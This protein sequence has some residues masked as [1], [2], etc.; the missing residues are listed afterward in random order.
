MAATVLML[1]LTHIFM[2]ERLLAIQDV[3]VPRG[4][5][6]F[7]SR[8]DKL[9]HLLNLKDHNGAI[10]LK[11]DWPV[12]DPSEQQDQTE[13]LFEKLKARGFDD[14]IAGN[15][16]RRRM[17]FGYDTHPLAGIFTQLRGTSGSAG[18]SVVRDRLRMNFK[19]REMLGEMVIAADDIKIS[20]TETVGSQRTI[21]MQD[22]T[23]GSFSLTY[24]DGSVSLNLNQLK[25]GAIVVE[26]TIDNNTETFSAQSFADLQEQHF[27][28]VKNWLVP[29]LEHVGFVMPTSKEDSLVKRAVLAKIASIQHRT[30]GQFQRL[31]DELESS[32]FHTR[33]KAS[34]KIKQQFDLWS[35]LV[36]QSLSTRQFSPEAYH[37][38]KLI[39]ENSVDQNPIEEMIFEQE[40]L[41][42]KEYLVTLF[43]IATRD[44]QQVLIRHLQQLTGETFNSPEAWLD[45]NRN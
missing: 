27:E 32:S 18:R 13:Q 16:A 37:R 33:E 12:V 17:S 24:L 23:D 30:P 40:L 6:P 21:E 44:E 4:N 38:L 43:E 36:T 1:L 25:E 10:Q 22:N 34:L 31:L 19:D 2:A 5:G 39:V 7:Q 45:T 15:L 14:K 8:K 11:R 20:L 35:D 28:F 42:S 26:R 41:T 3:A 29:T 9:Q